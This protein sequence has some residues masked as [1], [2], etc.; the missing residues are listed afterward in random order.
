METVTWTRAKLDS[1]KE[2]Y[3]EAKKQEAVE[4]TF[5]GHRFYTA[6]ARYLIEFLEGKLQ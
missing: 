1:L 5:D 2:T 4:F 3:H 6:Y